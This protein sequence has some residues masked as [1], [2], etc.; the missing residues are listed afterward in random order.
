MF[1][2]ICAALAAAFSAFGAAALATS[3]I[4]TEFDTSDGFVTGDFG[5]V[6]LAHGTFS[7]TF[8]GG[9]QQQGFDGPSYSAPPAAYMFINGLFAGSFGNTVAGDGVNDDAGLID[10]DIGAREVSFFAANRGN[11][12]GVTLNIF[13]VDD[14]TLLDTI[15]ITQTSNLV[16]DGA[17]MTVLSASALGGFI[18]SIAID[19]PGPAGAPPYVLAV[20]SFSATAIPVPAALPLFLAGLAGLGLWERRANRG[21]RCGRCSLQS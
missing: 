17:V 7:V 14:T 10:F 21:R 11:G 16:A 8:S 19:L 3:T 1:I 5:D 2:K 6:T 20:D 13:G 4:S 18:G 12:A 9:Q 15:V